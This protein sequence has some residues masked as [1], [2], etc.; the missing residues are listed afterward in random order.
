MPVPR[1]NSSNYPVWRSKLS[2][3][4]SRTI[5]RE[6]T[7]SMSQPFLMT[8]F[9]SFARR[10]RLRFTS[11]A[12]GS[13]SRLKRGSSSRREPSRSTHLQSLRKPIALKTSNIDSKWQLRPKRPAPIQASSI[14]F[15]IGQ[16]EIHK[17]IFSIDCLDTS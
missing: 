4:S 15:A 2:T 12:I 10:N 9:T 14:G 7:T 6:R 3:V 5:P 17:I 11:G 13:K 8:S 16:I 1:K